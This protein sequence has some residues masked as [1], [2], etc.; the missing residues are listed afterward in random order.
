MGDIE[1]AAADLVVTGSSSNTALV[2]NANIVFGG[3]GA[4]RTVT[5]TP[6]AN[7]FGTATITVTVTDANSGSAVDTFLLTVTSQ[8][9]LPTISDIAD[10]TIAEDGTTGAL[11]FTVGDME[12]AAADL[13]VS[14]GSSNTAL[15]PNANIVFGGSG[16]NRTVTVTPLANA[17]GTATITVT[18][19]D[20]NSGAAVDTFLLTVTSVADLLGRYVFYNS[21]TW[22]GNDGVA[23]AA[24]DAAVATDKQALLPGQTATF[25]NYTS[26]SK[27]INGVMIDLDDLAGTP[28]LSDFVFKVGNSNDPGTWSN[29]PAPLYPPAVRVGAGTNGSTRITLIWANDNPATAER[30]A[31]AI[32]KQWLQVTVLATANTGL[33]AAD[34]FYFG[35]AI[36]ESNTLVTISQTTYAVVNATD[37]IAARNNQHGLLPP[38]PIDDLYDYNR[39][40]KVDATDQIIARNHATSTLTGLRMI[41]A[42]SPP[43]GAMPLTGEGELA[44]LLIQVGHHRAG[45]GQARTDD[46]DLCVWRAASAGPE[47]QHPSCGRRAGNPRRQHRR[48]GDPACRYPDRH[49][50]RRQQHGRFG[51]RWFPSRRDPAGRMAVD[52]H[53]SGTVPAEGLLAVVTIDTTGFDRGSWVLRVSGTANGDTD[54]AGLAATLVDGSITIAHSWR[55]PRNPYDVNDD[56]LVSPLDALVTINY[57]NSQL[58]VS[59]LPVPRV[60][61]AVLRC[62]RR[63]VLHGGGR[64]ECRELPERPGA[65]SGAKAKGWQSGGRGQRSEIRGQRSEIE[66]ADLRAPTSEVRD[67]RSEVRGQGWNPLER[68]GAVQPELGGMLSPLRS[69]SKTLSPAV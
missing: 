30:E 5:V 31:G 3:S 34:V 1:T 53:R 21:S 28:T 60:A 50:F 29:A 63:R 52:H 23:N 56:G 24:D 16:A 38:G 65:G 51:R 41:T 64:A 69:P 45:T 14:G 43:A 19:T 15:V 6:L 42:P 49:D 17:F 20:A 61:A 55:N 33:P 48:S 13:V 32:S 37:E 62:Q 40:K 12:T 46:S 66:V 27:G 7:A 47:L 68:M 22:D 36:G 35:N 18:V 26:Y 11:A 9:D 67:Q 4:N 25:A 10:Q 39:D 44:G 57:V 54:F 59:A 8:N 58:G 2:P